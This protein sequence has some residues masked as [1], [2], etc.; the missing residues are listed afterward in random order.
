LSDT[1]AARE[2]KLESTRDTQRKLNIAH[3]ILFATK[4]VLPKTSETTELLARWLITKEEADR[5]LSESPDP[6]R[7]PFSESEK[8]I[9]VSE[10]EVQREMQRILRERSVAWVVGTSIAFEAVIMLFAC[11]IFC[12]RDF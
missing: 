7:S 9:R 4:T 8:D 5:L 12:R 10:K 6:P 11:W 2:K 3:S 1:Y